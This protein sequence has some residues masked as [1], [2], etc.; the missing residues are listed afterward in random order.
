MPRSQSPLA[1]PPVHDDCLAAANDAVALARLR[2][3]TTYAVVAQQRRLPANPAALFAAGGHKRMLVWQGG[4]WLLCC[5]ESLSASVSGPGRAVALAGIRSDLQH[6][7]CCHGPDAATLPILAL[8]CSF[9]PRAPGPSAWG[10]DLPGAELRLP[11]IAY[12]RCG[13]AHGRVIASCKV[14]GDDKPQDIASNLQ[15]LLTHGPAESAPP[16]RHDRS[17]WQPLSEQDFCAV[18]AEA[19]S[20]VHHG[21]LRK[22]VLARAH[23]VD[24]HGD[25]ASA[26]LL[27]ALRQQADSASTV[28]WYDLEGGASFIGTTPELLFAL[29]GNQLHSMALAGSRP[30]GQT[31]SED[32]RLARELVSST[33]ERKE[34]NLVVEHIARALDGRVSQLAIPAAPVVRKLPT[35][36]HLHSP[37]SATLLRPDP[38]DLLS[39]L[40]PTP[41]V[42]GLP[43]PLAADYIRRQEGLHR[44]LYSGVLGW[45]SPGQARMVVPLRGGIICGPR[46]R[47]FAGAGIVETS[48]PEAEA[49]EVESKLALMRG[50]L[51]DK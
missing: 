12:Q 42:C 50:V 27:S 30:R 47:L 6:R 24:W 18:V 39:Q 28:Y 45:L 21:A 44:G 14:H 36:Q 10:Q 3:G 33:K 41:A 19:A 35:M 13:N 11:R 20:L 25:H 23:D 22:V 51:G 32:R 4:D 9:E 43:S 16:P 8:A 38:C 5:G 34:H 29:N 7:C 15:E 49:A 17:R 48:Q 2:G 46:A 1:S 26:P 40:H 37:M 31:S